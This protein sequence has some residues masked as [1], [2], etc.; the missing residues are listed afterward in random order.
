[1]IVRISR[2]SDMAGVLRY[3]AGPGRGNEHVEPHLIGGDGAVLAWWDDA[4]LD[5]AAAQQ[6]GGVLDE[7][8]RHHGTEVAGGHVWHCSLSLPATEGQ[9]SD[10][11]WGQ[12]VGEFTAGMG[13]TVGSGRAPCRWVAVRHGLSKAGNDHVHLV[14]SLVRDDGTKAVVWNDY[15]RA[16]AAVTAIE[17]R[18]GLTVLEAREAGRG[19]RGVSGAELNKAVRLGVDEPARAVLGRQVRAYAVGSGDEAQFVRRARGAGL[20]I[21]PRYAAGRG[22]VIEGYSVAQ[23]PGR[24]ERPVWFGGGRLDRDLTLPR[25]RLGWVDT[26]QAASAAAAEWAAAARH[27]RPAAPAG[28]DGGRRVVQAGEWAEAAREVAGLR[29]RLLAIPVGDTA[30]W[31]AVAH[32][33][34][35]VLAAWSQ[36]LEPRP[37]PYAAA[38]DSLA[39]SAQTRAGDSR[40]PSRPD[41]PG[42]GA[43]R[44]AMLLLTASSAT[45][46]DAGLELLM[47]QLRNTWKAVHDAH[48]ATGQ[49]QAAARVAAL[50]A[51]PLAARAGSRPGTGVSVRDGD[52]SPAGPAPVPGLAT[53]VGTE[54]A[55]PSGGRRV[56]AAA[57][58]RQ[59]QQGQRPQPRPTIGGGGDQELSAPLPAPLSPRHPTRGRPTDDLDQEIAAATRDPGPGLDDGHGRG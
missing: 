6:I 25:L 31:S 11:R 50:A 35:G 48:L 3:L 10:E 24:G 5:R 36:R 4:V 29:D 14:V 41:D 26:P 18:H 49:A 9:L 13:F 54:G 23:R 44:A 27:R 52:R 56:T 45:P 42:R 37:G 1:M 34:A 7:P 17:R 43:R 51:A 2:G 8:R 33:S 57:R 12:I 28:V 58:A 55:A 32:D 19:S 38:A 30:T 39:R 40:P 46:A 47:R 22:D 21:R 15:R 20:L 53:G 16:G 59:L